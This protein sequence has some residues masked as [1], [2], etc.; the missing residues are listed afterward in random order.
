M[1]HSGSV[2]SLSKLQVFNAVILAVPV[3]VMNRLARKKRTTQVPGHHQPVF[4]NVLTEF[5][6]HA[7]KLEPGIPTEYGHISAS[8]RNPPTLPRKTLLPSDI[9]P[10]VGYHIHYRSQRKSKPTRYVLW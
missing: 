7:W 4:Q 9:L 1:P 3:N 6:K 10:L 8:L 5:S 2:I